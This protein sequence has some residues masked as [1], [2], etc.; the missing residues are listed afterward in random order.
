MALVYEKTWSQRYTDEQGVTW[1]LTD[2]EAH[3]GE[4]FERWQVIPQVEEPLPEK[5]EPTGHDEDEL[6]GHDSDEP[7]SELSSP[8]TEAEG[9]VQVSKDDREMALG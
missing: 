8:A 1:Q 6:T 9:N 5:R 2:L 7:T 4:V 3:D